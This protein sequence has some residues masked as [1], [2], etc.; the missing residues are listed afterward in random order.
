MI[1]E[2]YHNLTTYLNEL[3][4]TNKPEQQNNTFL[5]PTRENPGKT[6]DRIPMQTTILTELLELK[7]EKILTPQEDIESK[8]KFL[9]RFDWMDTLLTE[10]EKRAIEDIQVD[11]YNIFPKRRMDIGMDTEFK[12]K[13]TQ[14]DGEAVYSQNLPTPMH[15][16]G[17]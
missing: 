3:L 12:V 16:K 17:T 10:V 11:H 14:K 9:V 13:L 5:F 7:E 2:G 15:L 1:P 4:K 8:T 6:E